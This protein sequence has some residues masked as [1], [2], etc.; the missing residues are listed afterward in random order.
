S[1]VLGVCK[2]FKQDRNKGSWWWQV[3]MIDL[4]NVTENV[5]IT[6]TIQIAKDDIFKQAPP[7]KESEQQEENLFE[8]DQQVSEES[9]FRIKV[10][11]NLDFWSCSENNVKISCDL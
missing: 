11:P 2:T 1:V 5:T 9:S 10:R 7:Y 4:M 3:W 6:R 8:N